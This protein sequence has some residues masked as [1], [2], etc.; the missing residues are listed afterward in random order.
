MVERPT[1]RSRIAFGDR[2]WLTIA[3]HRNA[4]VYCLAELT[5]PPYEASPG[6]FGG[7]RTDIY[8]T[9]HRPSPPPHRHPDVC[10]AR[11][12]PRPLWIP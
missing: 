9:P 1:Y 11:G 6:D 10:D 4:G 8:I 7:W 2:V 3:A 5:S 12:M